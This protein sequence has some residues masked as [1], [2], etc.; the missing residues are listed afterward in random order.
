MLEG[1]SFEHGPRRVLIVATGYTENT[2]MGW[3]DEEKTTVGTNWGRPPSL[4]EAVAATI[5]FSRRG[6]QA[7]LPTVYALDDRGQR[8]KQL[9]P[10]AAGEKVEVEI[11]APNGTLWYEIEFK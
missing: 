1:D 10:S 7:A 11:G 8:A 3:K 2:A 6:E 5:R 9:S 4:V